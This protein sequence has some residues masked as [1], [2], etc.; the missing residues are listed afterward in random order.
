MKQELTTAEKGTD[1]VDL[2]VKAEDETDNISLRTRRMKKKAK[3]RKKADKSDQNSNIKG[4]HY[5]KRKKNTFH[6]E[7]VTDEDLE[8]DAFDYDNDD[9]ENDPSFTMSSDQ[10][11]KLFDDNDDYNIITDSELIGLNVSPRR[12]RR[13]HQ[14]PEEINFK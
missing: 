5:K 4:E 7:F 13:K 14:E 2:E 11:A 12:K 3:A 1:T 10:E 9:F 6:S 8:M